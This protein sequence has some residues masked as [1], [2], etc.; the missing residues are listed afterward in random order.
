MNNAPCATLSSL[1]FDAAYREC[2]LDNEANDGTWLEPV[3][4]DCISATELSLIQDV[5]T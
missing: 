1:L 3:M 5:R 2:V 4:D